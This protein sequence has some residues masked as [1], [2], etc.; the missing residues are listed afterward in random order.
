MSINF[1]AIVRTLRIENGGDASCTEI[2]K[3]PFR[4]PGVCVLTEILARLPNLGVLKCSIRDD[5]WSNILSIEVARH[6]SG[7]DKTVTL[8]MP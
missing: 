5:E 1:V 7:L 4:K 6:H 3:L 2:P 8:L